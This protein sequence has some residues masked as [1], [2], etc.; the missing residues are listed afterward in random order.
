MIQGRKQPLFNM[1]LDSLLNRI[2]LTAIALSILAP[3][4][5]MHVGEGENASECSIH[6]CVVFFR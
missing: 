2:M 5:S 4:I 3:L 6:V 1:V